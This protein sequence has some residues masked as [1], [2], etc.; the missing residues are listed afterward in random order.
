MDVELQKIVDMVTSD[1]MEDELQFTHSSKTLE[2]LTTVG[3]FF[4][5]FLFTM[6]NIISI[7][8]FY[9]NLLFCTVITLR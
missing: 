5:H 2:D 9:L 8:I 6:S 7:Y 3:K 1:N 4:F